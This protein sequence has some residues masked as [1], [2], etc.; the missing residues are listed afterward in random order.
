[1]TNDFNLVM[2]GYGGQG[3]ITAAEIVSSAAMK[4][5][6]EAKEAELHGLA[7]RGG[8]LDC[9]IRFGKKI[10][11][12]VVTRGCADL[13]IAFD[14]LEALRACYWANKKTTIIVNAKAFRSDLK[15]NEL[16]SRIRKFAKLQIID[17]DAISDK[18]TGDITAVNVFLVAYA[19][20]KKLL[21]LKK[22]SAWKAV[23]DKINPRFLDES[24]KV[25]DE[26]F[27]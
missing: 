25:F 17:A 10:Y 22:E 14:A 5:G 2:V 21:P 8:S 13:I 15:L 19:I 1:M 23:Q 11:S 7:Q 4:S 9:H 26:A 3:I 6:L 27:R 16:Y 24:K 20:R 18:L 12:P